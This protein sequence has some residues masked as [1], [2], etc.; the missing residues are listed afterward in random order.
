MLIF[1][2]TFL[3]NPRALAHE[4]K[5]VYSH[6]KRNLVERGTSLGRYPLCCYVVLC[7]AVTFLGV[8][9]YYVICLALLL[10]VVS[11]DWEAFDCV[12]LCCGVALWLQHFFLIFFYLPYIQYFTLLYGSVS[13]GLGTTKF[14]NLIG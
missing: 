4:K 5:T 10:C 9:L 2:L 13:Q 12:A 1:V 7:F 8:M 11:C 3:S 6:L 14:A